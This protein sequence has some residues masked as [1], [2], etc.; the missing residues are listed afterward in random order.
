MKRSD[1]WSRDKIMTT[2]VGLFQICR[3]ETSSDSLQPSSISYAPNYHL[4]ILKAERVCSCKSLGLLDV[5]VA[6]VL[7]SILIFGSLT[8]V[9]PDLR[10]S[11]SAAAG[12]SLS[13]S[14]GTSGKLRI[15]QSQGFRVTASCPDLG[16]EP[17][18]WGQT[19]DSFPSMS[20]KPFYTTVLSISTK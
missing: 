7:C 17:G 18:I 1:E 9:F 3:L 19:D 4:C 10:G 16:T 11:Q 2:G 6:G 20:T 12:F 5:P 13:L 14:W 8:C 15:L